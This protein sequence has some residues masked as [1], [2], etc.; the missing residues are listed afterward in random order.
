MFCRGYRSRIN[1][2]QEAIWVCYSNVG[3]RRAADPSLTSDSMVHKTQKQQYRTNKTKML[4]I[5]STKL[6]NEEVSEEQE[7]RTKST[8]SITNRKLERM[9]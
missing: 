7:K 5:K 8:A 3:N 6:N 4:W 2:I 1:F 9:K